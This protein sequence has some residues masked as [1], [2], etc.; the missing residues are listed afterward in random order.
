[1]ISFSRIGNKGRFLIIRLRR[2]NSNKDYSNN[3]EK[4]SIHNINQSKH[5][6]LKDL[7]IT[8]NL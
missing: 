2:Y 8:E 7:A 3:L 5:F 4:E 6:I 1:M